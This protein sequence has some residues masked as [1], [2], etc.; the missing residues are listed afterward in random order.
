MRTSFRN[1]GIFAF[2]VIAAF[3]G[4]LAWGD[5]GGSDMA[6]TAFLENQ[7][8]STSEPTPIPLTPVAPESIA[9]N[10]PIVAYANYSEDEIYL[11][12]AVNAQ[13]LADALIVASNQL[14]PDGAVT[15]EFEILTGVDLSIV[16][17]EIS[18]QIQDEPDRARVL[19]KF[20]ALGVKVIDQLIIKGSQ[21]TVFEV[22]RDTPE[23]SQVYDFFSAAGIEE[24]L[25]EEVVSLTVFAPTNSAM[26]ALDITALQEFA[27]LVQ[28]SDILQFH[29][30]PGEFFLNQFTSDLNITTLNGETL[31]LSTVNESTVLVEEASITNADIVAANGVIHIIDSVLIP[32]TIK[33]EI[34]LNQ[35]VGSDPVLFAVGS[36]FI[37]ESSKSV[38]E[39]VAQIL[40]ENPEG[41]LEVEGHSDTDGPEDI[42]LDLSKSRAEAVMEFLISKGVEPT[43][44][45]AIGY[46]ETRLKVDPEVTAQDRADNRRIEFRVVFGLGENS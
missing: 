20:N 40:I 25:G 6:I 45:S 8:N 1:L 11:S 39:R 5:G 36:P 18:G 9:Q 29:I 32:G 21:R 33:T 14:V 26:E 15:A 43:R 46:G 19:E 38:L 16:N 24:Q 41:N 34:A 4:L 22:I 3:V 23:L 13:A 27:Q 44:I 2:G 31:T 42:N 37:A 30:V 7:N 10:A 12:G 17:L 35:I 28:L